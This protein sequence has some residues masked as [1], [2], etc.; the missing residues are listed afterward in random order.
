VLA[1]SE[2]SRIDRKKH[3]D[4]PGRSQDAPGPIRTREVRW[5]TFTNPI[6]F[7]TPLAETTPSENHLERAV[8]I[9]G[10]T[11][12]KSS[13]GPK[14]TMDRLEAQVKARGLSVF[15]R[16][17]HAAGASS[18]GLTLRPTEVLIFGNPTGGTPLMQAAQTI[19]LE[20]PLK[21]LVWQDASGDS[22]LSYNDPVWLA[23]RYGLAGETEMV[24]GKLSAALAAVALAAT[25]SL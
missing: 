17:D 21:A 16:I 10:L 8:A 12:I 13:F 24:A 18:A 6:R 25:T 15:A 9:D 20:L 1:F 3:V 11:T 2:Y 7:P 19:G 23:R 4:L 14:D 22:W 5:R